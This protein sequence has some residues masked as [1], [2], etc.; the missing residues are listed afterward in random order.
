V[1][2]IVATLRIAPVAADAVRWVRESGSE[3]DAMPQ[4]NA[5]D[6]F[7]CFKQHPVADA[8]DH[9]LA[10]GAPE[11]PKPRRE[12]IEDVVSGTFC[13]MLASKVLAAR[14]GD[15]GGPT[16]TDRSE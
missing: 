14:E 3:S 16:T 4:P 1:V 13:V 2:A 12:M 15:D 8:R 6:L 10:E 7:H 9:A 11:P 5:G